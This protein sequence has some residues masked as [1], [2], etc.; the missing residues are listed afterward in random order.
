M[1][2][3]FAVV[4]LILGM[5]TFA[6]AADASLGNDPANFNKLFNQAWLTA[7]A[8]FMKAVCA[9][10]FRLTITDQKT[11][12]LKPQFVNLVANGKYKSRDIVLDQVERHG[13]VVIATAHTRVV[14]E[15][16][17]RPGILQIQT[18]VFQLGKDNVW[19]V[20]SMRAIS[21]AHLEH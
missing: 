17:K 7:D 12:M 9:D 16:P 10:D 6:T 18:R 20:I 8:D 11:V 15:D 21:E 2:A 5:N 13:D 19:R 1:R 3:M 4:A 14:Y